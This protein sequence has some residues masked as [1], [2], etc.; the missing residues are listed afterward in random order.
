VRLLSKIVCL[1]EG[2]QFKS[3]IAQK[4]ATEVPLGNQQE[5][6]ARALIAEFIH[7]ASPKEIVIASNTTHAIDL[8]ALGFN[9]RPGDVVGCLQMGDQ[10]PSLPMPTLG[11][12]R[13]MFTASFQI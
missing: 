2:R 4:I 11:M 9:F 5:S 3:Q 10:P 7:A 12:E 1:S 13:A 8:V 6:K